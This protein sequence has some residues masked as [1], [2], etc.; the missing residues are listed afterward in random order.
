MKFFNS[1]SAIVMVAALL[2]LGT[3]AA[4]IGI[5]GEL[6]WTWIQEWAGSDR[7]LLICIGA[8]LICIGLM[9]IL[10]ALPCR[11]NAYVTFNTEGGGVS[12]S[13]HAIRDYLARAGTEDP[14][15]LSVRPTV[16]A[17]KD[18]LKVTLEI[19]V[20]AG[21]SIPDIGQAIQT[22]VRQSIERDLGLPRVETIRVKIVEI[23]GTS[24]SAPRRSYPAFGA[25][26]DNGE[27]R[28]VVV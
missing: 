21:S 18:S 25:A 4:A 17:Q 1:L 27:D 24:S 15:I 19:R 12:V 11:A 7:V 23:A 14:S 6:G 26:G 13:V 10:T 22:R 3:L 20:Q 16:C 5:A 9:W 8:G 2:F 28:S